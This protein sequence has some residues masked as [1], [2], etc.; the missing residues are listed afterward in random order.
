MELKA[1]VCEKC[2]AALAFDAQNERLFCQHCGASYMMDLGLV[3]KWY[4]RAK[5]WAEIGD[6]EKEK[7]CY[8]TILEIDP[9]ENDAW[10][11]LVQNI[12]RIKPLE[13][14]SS[15]LDREFIKYWHGVERTGPKKHQ[16]KQAIEYAS[17]VI[18]YCDD[19]IEH[20]KKFKNNSGATLSAN[21]VKERWAPLLKKWRKQLKDMENNAE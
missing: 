15:N 21:L 11:G 2:G 7:K 13:M 14:A 19:V 18:K 16:L 3:A 6:H 10:W 5:K 9:S 1:A 4:Q 17:D 8:E 12:M 20:Y